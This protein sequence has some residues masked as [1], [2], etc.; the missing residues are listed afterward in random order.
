MKKV[1][2]ELIGSYVSCLGGFVGVCC[3]LAL[4][5]APISL[6]GLFFIVVGAVLSMLAIYDEATPVQKL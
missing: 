4:N 3:G 6:L 5:N 2:K 1:D